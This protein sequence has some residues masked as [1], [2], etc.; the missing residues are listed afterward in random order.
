V[1]LS[2]PSNSRKPEPGQTTYKIVGSAQRRHRGAILQHGS[3]LLERSSAAPELP[4]WKELT[5][6]PLPTAT[7]IAGLSE[8]L[9]VALTAEMVATGL[10]EPVST[11]ARE[12]ER[13]KYGSRT[14]TRR[15]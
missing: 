3:V 10:P 5:G 2:P 6:V 13:T 8:Q 1:L 4:G 7:L 14:W 11:M 9:A 12:I 15:R